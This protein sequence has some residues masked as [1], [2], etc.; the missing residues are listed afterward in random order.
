M[1][2]PHQSVDLSCVTP[3][4]C[5]RRKAGSDANLQTLDGKFATDIARAHKYAAIEMQL[6]G[7]AL[8]DLGKAELAVQFVAAR[9]VGKV[10]LG[11][12]AR[13]RS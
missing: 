6:G 12:G 11:L 3:S 13:S 2:C 9:L 8:D 5:P 1:M 4:C 7:V 10:G